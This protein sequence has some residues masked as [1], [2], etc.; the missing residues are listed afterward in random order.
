MHQRQR[1]LRQRCCSLPWAGW[2]YRNPSRL[3]LPGCRHCHFQGY[4]RRQLRAPH[5]TLSQS[6]KSLLKWADCVGGRP[7]DSPAL[8]ILP[9]PMPRNRQYLHFVD[10]PGHHYLKASRHFHPRF[11]KSCQSSLVLTHHR[12]QYHPSF[13]WTFLFPFLLYDIRTKNKMYFINKFDKLLQVMSASILLLL[14]LSHR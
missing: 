9:W 6:G 1:L 14:I 12:R 11:A 3:E 13:V 4:Q 2:A 10:W 7:T 5:S 8:S